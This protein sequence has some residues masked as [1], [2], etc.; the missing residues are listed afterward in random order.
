MASASTSS[1]MTHRVTSPPRT[2]ERRTVAEKLPIEQLSPDPPALMKLLESIHWAKQSRQ[3]R[4][5]QPAVATAQT[6]DGWFRGVRKEPC[7]NHRHGSMMSIKA[8]GGPAEEAP[9]GIRTELKDLGCQSRSHPVSTSSLRRI[10][11]PRL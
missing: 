5:R 11:L 8:S 3:K 10:N 2:V 1:K 9:G 4:A 7:C 6:E